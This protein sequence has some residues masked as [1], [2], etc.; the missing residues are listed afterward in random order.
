MEDKRIKEL[1]LPDGWEAARD[2]DGKV[3][4][5]DHHNKRTTWIDPRDSYA[6]PSTFADC[7][8]NE[9]PVGWEEAYDPKI[10]KYYINH[11]EHTNQIED[12]RLTWRSVQEQMLKDYLV[13][14]KENLET[15]QELVIMK[16]ERLNLAQKEYAQL[17]NFGHVNHSTSSLASTG[18]SGSNKYDPDLIKSDV[19]M[20]KHRVSQLRHELEV[21]RLEM[22]S[23]KKGLS[24]LEKVDRKMSVPN[25]NYSLPEAHAILSELRN[26][27]KSLLIGQKEKAELLATLARMRDNR[28]YR[29]DRSLDSSLFSLT[30]EKISTASQTDISGELMS[31]KERVAQ[32]TRLRLEYDEARRRLQMVQRLLAELEDKVVPG[33]SEN[34]RD[35]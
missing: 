11:L 22:L 6:K 13:T 27:Q 34:D 24:L 31:P 10:G 20:S 26:I 23:Q 12:P 14:A 25:T 30:S 18:S 17:S 3:Y 21:A 5:I 7:V 32:L 15:K 19:L 29:S 28:G 33:Q 2:I 8:G 9:L 4:Y 16:E 1:S 35:R